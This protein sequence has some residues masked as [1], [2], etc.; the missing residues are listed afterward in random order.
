M[1]TVGHAFGRDR[2]RRHFILPNKLEI[3]GERLRTLC[4]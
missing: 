1:V 4:E 2:G 3:G